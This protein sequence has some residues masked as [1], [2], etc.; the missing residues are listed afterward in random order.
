MAETAQQR[1]AATLEVEFRKDHKRGPRIIFKEAEKLF[2]E[3]LDRSGLQGH[4]VLVPID[5]TK[6]SSNNQGFRIKRLDANNSIL[7]LIQPSSNAT[8]W[9]YRLRLPKNANAEEMSKRLDAAANPPA[10]RAPKEA[11]PPKAVVAAP[12]TI[13][14]KPVVPTAETPSMTAR[15]FAVD[16]ERVALT[17]GHFFPLYNSTPKASEIVEFLSKECVWQT[18]MAAEALQLLVNRGHFKFQGSNPRDQQV[19]IG[20][21]GLVNEFIS[22]GMLVRPRPELVRASI[23]RSSHEELEAKFKVGVR[24]DAEAPKPKPA[25]AKAV[26]KRFAE[27]EQKARKF[28]EA[29]EAIVRLE[30]AQSEGEERLKQARRQLLRLKN[31]KTRVERALEDAKKILEDPEY[32]QAVQKLEQ[33]R[34]IIEE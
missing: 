4:F 33:V 16:L 10:V 32:A 13:A 26:P 22:L 8:A 24:F 14:P 2:R 34:S 25:S 1:L 12:V 31:E 18:A 7:V 21:S 3:I 5:A 28:E 15:E 29:K 23:A 30:L 11:P 9:E 19:L 27:L 17:I 6:G 20:G